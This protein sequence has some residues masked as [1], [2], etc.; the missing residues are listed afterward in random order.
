[1][2]KTRH[3]CA[4]L[5]LRKPPSFKELEGCLLADDFEGG[6][7]DILIGTDRIYDIVLWNQVPLAKRLRA[8][9]T[10]FGGIHRNGKLRVVFDGSA[11]DGSG[12]SLNSYLDLG[13]NLLSCLLSVIISFRADQVGC[14]SDIK[15]AFH[16]IL[17]K[18]EARKYVQF[19]WADEIL[20]F[21]RVPF[22]LSCSPFML[23]Q[24]IA[25]HVHQHPMIGPDLRG[26]IE[27]GIYMDDLCLSF[28]S[29]DKAEASLKHVTNIFV[30]ASIELHKLRKTETPSDESK[31]LS[32]KWDTVADHLAKAYCAG[33]YAVH[34]RDSRM[35]VAKGRLAPFFQML[36][37]QHL[38][39]LAAFI[40]IKLMCT[41]HE[42]LD[43]RNPRTIYWT[44]SV[45]VLCWIKTNKPLKILRNRVLSIRQLSTPNQWRYV[46]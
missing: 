7:I 18:E 8:I 24:T 17:I 38:E 16:Q 44:D 12:R 26:R 13:V 11:K 35:L 15:A 33:V 5:Q 19:L 20:R 4:P 43:L 29:A 31:V 1:M 42:A 28:P 45:S 30:D 41:I 37:I 22:G 3:L 25:T 10:I 9:E 32:L 23:L 34:R 2:W 14:Q 36:S 27:R 39:L 6:P 21:Q 46:N 40:G